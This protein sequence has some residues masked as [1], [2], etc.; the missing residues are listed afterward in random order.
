MGH[1]TNDV[2]SAPGGGRVLAGRHRDIRPNGIESTSGVGT[3][4]ISRTVV[5]VPPPTDPVDP[6]PP[7][8]PDSAFETVTLLSADS[9]APD[10]TTPNQRAVLALHG[11]GTYTQLN[12]GSAQWQATGPDL[13]DV[14]GEPFR[15]RLR[16]S[17]GNFLINPLCGEPGTGPT[18][19]WQGW[20]VGDEMHPY[21]ERRLDALVAWVLATYPNVS[22]TK[23][24]LGGSSI[25]AWA[26]INYG[27]RRPDMFAALFPSR[28]RWRYGR[29]NTEVDVAVRGST[30]PA[31]FTLA[32]S[33]LVTGYSGVRVAEYRDSVAYVADSSH[34]IP[35]VAW[36]VG[37][38]DEYTPFQ[39]HIDAVDALR[40]TGRGFAFAWDNEGHES[41]IFTTGIDN[42]YTE[43]MFELGVGWPVLTNSS[44]DQD[45]RIDSIGGINVG[46]K[47]RNIVET[48][49]TWSCELFNV[50]G[51][52]TVTVKPYSKVFRSAVAPKTVTVPA[53]SWLTVTF[54]QAAPVVSPPGI[55]STSAF[56]TPRI[57]NPAV[58]RPADTVRVMDHV[59]T[60]VC[61]LSYFAG[62]RY[63]RYNR[64]HVLAD[65]VESI[66]FRGVALA[67]GGKR[68]LSAT[69]YT[70]LIDGVAYTTVSPPAGSYVSA[71]SVN[72]ADLTEGWH[73][74][75]IMVPAGETAIPWVVYVRKGGPL[76]NP[77][78]PVVTTTFYMERN[79]T[80][81]FRISWVPTG[82]PMKHEPLVR[83][84]TPAF[85]TALS[86][87]KL[88]L[89]WLVPDLG[90]HIPNINPQGLI[91]TFDRLSYFFSDL[92]DK[93]P[94]LPITDGPR[95]TACVQMLTHVQLDRHG[96]LYC[97]D[98]WRILRID[99]T[100]K[101]TT[102]CGYRHNPIPS[103]WTDGSGGVST[104]AQSYPTLELVGDWSA[105]PVERRGF[106][107]M[108]GL[109]FDL[110]SV[111]EA[112]LDP[113]APPQVNPIDG[114]IEQ[115]HSVGPRMFVSDTQNNRICLLTFQRDSFDAP[116]VVTEFI[117]GL[118]D[119][120]EVLWHEGK[121]YVSERL[122][123]RIAVYS[124]TTG[125]L[126]DVL[127][128]GPNLSGVTSERY[129]YR[130]GGGSAVQED[131][132]LANIR[133]YPCVGP[134]GLFIQD[135]WLYF[136]SWAMAQVRRVNLT[137]K[138]LQV[139]TPHVSMDG[140]SKYMKIA[141]S[142]GT[143]GPR[144]TVFIWTWTVNRYGFPS[145]YLP[146]G[147]TWS[148]AT[149]GN[150]L[151][152]KGGTWVGQGYT[153]A[154]GVGAGALYTSTSAKGVSM[155]SQA[156]PSAPTGNATLYN[157]GLTDMAP[158]VLKNGKY[159]F[160][161]HGEPPP[162]GISTALDYFLTW[163]GVT[164]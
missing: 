102:R 95:G 36:A 8:R 78:T 7:S 128:S 32:A 146:D 51:A 11:T 86:R 149:G 121:L 111:S 49:T 4:T 31:T 93:Y 82:V 14:P 71:F 57:S 22:R 21:H 120:W 139:Y 136:G 87:T 147:T 122:N 50:K 46:F 61:F 19:A 16:Q 58:T 92:V 2:Y 151:R 154:G 68:V 65:P 100:G 44:R 42:T 126:V 140:N 37:S 114:V 145:A 88:N 148:L 43:D 152:G 12:T 142:D 89:E 107:E 116:P 28:P 69:A 54:E 106:H 79:Q 110:D 133:S 97:A 70:L 1:P 72:L 155:I 25:G 73:V 76:N 138:E 144:G 41:T 125:A 84:D 99:K 94:S 13:S 137:T 17:V 59:G 66:G 33:P 40:A 6:D 27:L 153:S 75:D 3:P 156:V 90:M 60:S 141:L 134:E 83:P 85:D 62:D 158:Y 30:T 123:H 18:G 81:P 164:P 112:T 143:F 9:F 160:S 35:F 157:Q 34:D 45:P 124:A 56:G 118:N 104:T 117:T 98:P 67:G 132:A 113:T 24:T 39:D 159:G 130:V 63:N 20:M 26:S 135:G 162:F 64:L 74:M 48:A 91:S 127:A 119:P 52:T 55:S 96:G 47:W 101:V 163:N 161:P 53:G 150:F 77:F 105:I 80:E 10:G 115:P 131:A 108:W 38:Q 129:P 15:Y 29:N 103:Q 5:I 109:S 23:W